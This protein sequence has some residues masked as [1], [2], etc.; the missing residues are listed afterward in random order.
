MLSFSC[1]SVTPIPLCYSPTGPWG[2][3]HFIL[4]H[5]LC[6]SDLVICIV[7]FFSSLMLSSIPSNL[8]LSVC[9]IFIYFCYQTLQSKFPSW[10][11]VTAQMGQ[12]LVTTCCP[13]SLHWH[14]PG[15]EGYECL[16]TTPHVASNGTMRGGQQVSSLLGGGEKYPLFPRPLLTP[17]QQAKVRAPPYCQ[18]GW[19][20]RLPTWSPS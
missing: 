17:L 4:V 12:L 14:L 6:C 11:P 10:P 8:L 5:L 7:L 9:L 19:K 18:V 16:T 2:S 1:S 20:S 15:W 3:F 13:P